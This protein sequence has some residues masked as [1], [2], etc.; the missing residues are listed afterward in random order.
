MNDGENRKYQHLSL[1][2]FA[3][4]YIRS[5]GILHGNHGGRTHPL[6]VRAS[7]SPS[8]LVRILY[9]QFSSKVVYPSYACS[10]M[11]RSTPL[12]AASGMAEVEP[13]QIGGNVVW[14]ER[15]DG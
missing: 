3:Q 12:D 13:M 1:V 10:G 2:N 8:D 6:R 15:R 4:H 5:S 11:R 7:A 14:I 9:E